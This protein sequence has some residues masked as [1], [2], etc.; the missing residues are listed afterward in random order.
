MQSA[1]GGLRNTKENEM[2]R[3][4]LQTITTKLDT[5]ALTLKEAKEFAKR[6]GAKVEGRTRDQFLK[7]LARQVA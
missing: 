1:L 6:F 7:S 3:A 4:T 2:D 5:K